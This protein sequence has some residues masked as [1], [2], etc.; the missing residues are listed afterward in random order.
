MSSSLQTILPAEYQ[1]ACH[2]LEEVGGIP[3][4]EWIDGS[5]SRDARWRMVS[6]L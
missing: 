6:R 3:L 4:T 1:V 5:P 2:L